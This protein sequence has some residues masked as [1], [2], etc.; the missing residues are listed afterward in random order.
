MSEKHKKVR[1]ALNYF[2]HFLIFVSAVSGFVSKSA[3]ASVV[4]VAAGMLSPA[5]GLKICTI[6]GGIKMYK[7]I[8]K[9][10]TEKHDKIVLIGKPKLD[11]IEILISKVLIDS[12]IRY[13]EFFFSK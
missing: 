13:E 10:K 7:L 12:Y 4:D 6:I 1:R 3:F 9:K 5:V 8:I 2:E 11:P